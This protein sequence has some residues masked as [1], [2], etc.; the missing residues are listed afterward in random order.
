MVLS[1]VQDL[2]PGK[3]MKNKNIKTTSAIVITLLFAGF[4]NTLGLFSTGTTSHHSH[5]STI[6]QVAPAPLNLQVQLVADGASF[7]LLLIQRYITNYQ[8]AHPNVTISY[9]ATGSGKGQR[10]FINK[11]VDFAASD[12]PL[13]SQQRILAPKALHI[14]ET[15][16]AVTAAYNLLDSNGVRIPTGSLNLDGG[17]IAN[18]YLGSIKNWNDPA[19]QALNPT[20]LLP[21]QPIQVVFRSDSS[22]T[23]FVWTSYL[24][25][26][27]TTWRTT[28]N[29][30]PSTGGSTYPWPV[31]AGAALN[32]GV[33]TK[34]NTTAYA[35]GY[36]ELAYVI[37]NGMTVANVKNPAGNFILPTKPTTQN[38]VNDGAS[39]LPAGNGD[40]SAVNLLNEPGANDYPIVSFTY[41]F[42]YQELNV[43][44]SM[45]LVDNVQ[46]TVLKDFLNYCVTTGQSLGT[47]PTDLGFVAL[48]ASVVSLDQAT[49]NS[50]T[51]SH[52]STPVT[53]T[54]N[55][56]V[57]GT[58][59]NVSSLT[60]TSGDTIN[61]NFVSSDGLSHQWYV[62]F[63]NNGVMDPNEAWPTQAS[64]VFSS[65]TTPT[66]WPFHPLIW[67]QEGIP[68]AGSYTFRDANNAALTGSI[69]VQ[70]QQT[71]AVFRPNSALTSGL[72][73][74]LDNSRASTIGSLIID[75]RTKTVSGL[76][77]AVAV[78]SSDT[79]FG[80]LTAN[81]TYSIPNLQ[82]FLSGA[83][84]TDLS[85]V[86]ALDLGVL[87]LPLSTDVTVTLHNDFTASTQHVLT[88]ELDMAKQGSVNIVDVATVAFYFGQPATN[89]PAA[90]L[91]ASGGTID[92][93]DVAT[94][95]F[96]FGDQAFR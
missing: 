81:K 80:S 41:F 82:L 5:P 54:V 89:F 61:F 2:R 32:S 43:V 90:D 18:I 85:V 60:V 3:P 1:P 58:G 8:A 34:I 91:N 57:G 59:W 65:S 12:A 62:D 4:F 95:A 47:T 14:P 31:G 73:P 25:Q 40:W 33:A 7:P 30:G 75:Q 88:R 86:F 24:S 38:A 13:S 66:P 67:N 77:S 19:I 74:V 70:P 48:P 83:G 37:V 9:T 49:I 72:A 92:I 11:T 78:P 64:P 29:L 84:S 53:R 96:Y 26:E 10:D 22:G 16:G 51:F 71:A 68:A 36:V 39:G 79:K 6:P 45:D 27:S 15:I 28:P 63:N 93:V 94:V 46:A 69:T 44:H 87:P 17:T 52:V 23:S 42:V 76:A 35:F 56:G 55:V 21:N 50:I 20:I